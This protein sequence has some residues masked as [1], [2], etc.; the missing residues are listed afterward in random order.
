[1]TSLLTLVERF[2][3][4]HARYTTPAGVTLDV[5]REGDTWKGYRHSAPQT[6]SEVACERTEEAVLAQLDKL[7]C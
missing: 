4:A 6:L 7:Y 5:V 1:M 3:D 2:G